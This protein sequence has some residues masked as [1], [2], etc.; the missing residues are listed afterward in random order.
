MKIPI[1]SSKKSEY[2]IDVYG[3]LDVHLFPNK[4]FN[5]DL[6]ILK[7]GF[8]MALITISGSIIKTIE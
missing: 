1:E 4:R 8:H 5:V 3:V 2:S 6:K 7:F